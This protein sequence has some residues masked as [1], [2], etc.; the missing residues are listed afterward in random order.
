MTSMGIPSEEAWGHP[1]IVT[2]GTVT[3]RVT[4]TG[5]SEIVGPSVGW[6]LRQA[7]TRARTRALEVPESRAG[8][9]TRWVAAV[10]AS[11]L[12]AIVAL[13]ELLDRF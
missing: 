8:K 1:T 4:A 7:L 10:V 5:T 12:T 3:I 13:L 2:S 9:L 6:R 11:V